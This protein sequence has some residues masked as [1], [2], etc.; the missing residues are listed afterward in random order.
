LKQPDF[1]L[2]AG[3]Q[4]AQALLRTDTPITRLRGQWTEYQVRGKDGTPTGTSIPT[5]PIF[6]PGYLLRRPSEKRLAWQ[7]L[8]AL[9]ARLAGH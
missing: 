8:L 1:L 9:S 2:L 6:H 5:M 4:C 3:G 7:D